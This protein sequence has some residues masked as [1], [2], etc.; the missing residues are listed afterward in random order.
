MHIQ[1][2]AAKLSQKQPISAFL[3][4]FKTQEK[5]NLQPELETGPKTQP[6]QKG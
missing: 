4:L 3:R 2:L 1:L 5:P 6:P